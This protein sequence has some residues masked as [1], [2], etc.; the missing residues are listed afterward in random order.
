MV[1]ERNST[2]ARAMR[3]LVALGVSIV[4]AGPG[5]ARAHQVG[6]DPVV[7]LVAAVTGNLLTI[8][9]TVPLAVLT[10]AGL[11]LDGE[12]RDIPPASLDLVG[13][14]LA[15]NLELS[16]GDRAL[17]ARS[18][19]S[20]LTADRASVDVEIVYGID[21]DDEPVS[22]RLP[23]YSLG[24]VPIRTVVRY[25]HPP[26]A[27]RVFVVTADADR[28]AFDPTPS[29]VVR[30]VATRAAGTLAGGDFL[31]FA[32]CLIVPGR[33]AGDLA[34]A[35]AAWLAAECLTIPAAGAGLVELTPTFATLVQVLAA[36]TVVVAALLTAVT[37]T[38]RWLRPL[39][40]AF[41]LA[42]GLHLGALF[43]GDAGYAGSHVG[44]GLTT[45]FLLSVFG[46]LWVVALLS[47]A[48]GLL[49][50]WGLPRRAA[51]FGLVAVAAHSALHRLA[52]GTQTLASATGTA[53]DRYGMAIV[54][55]WCAAVL[56]AGIAERLWLAGAR[57]PG[58][59]SAGE[60]PGASTS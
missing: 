25:E 55:G 32:L 34:R 44:V 41:G 43:A 20:T 14:D 52:D 51:L 1:L 16:Q 56:C 5:T 57:N 9:A 39:A 21:P 29:Q 23:P 58:L 13:R 47:S 35:C 3:W 17:P 4:T 19:G 54:L 27:S 45:F 36:S 53:A 30:G 48:V 7:D 22:A 50:Y 24:G 12:A 18:I 28:V 37:P 49:L 8:R 6:P 15:A 2:L 26:A 31:F 11:R 42:H 46:Q 40:F 33:K 10:G 59:A 38:S 60:T